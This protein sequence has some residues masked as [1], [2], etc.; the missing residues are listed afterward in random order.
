METESTSSL[1]PD[2]TKSNVVSV[3]ENIKSKKEFKKIQLYFMR[4]FLLAVIVYLLVTFLYFTGYFAE[5]SRKFDQNIPFY[6]GLPYVAITSFA[7]VSIFWRLHPPKDEDSRTPTYE[8]SIFNL[9]FSGPG[10]PIVLWLFC[11]LS[12]VLSVVLL[13]H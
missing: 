12:G 3:D 6:I 2:G 7:I 13:S 1:K 9:R 4:A 10:G 5:L 8:F 11:F